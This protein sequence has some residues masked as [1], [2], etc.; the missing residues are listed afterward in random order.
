[1]LFVRVGGLS[2]K[3]YRKNKTSRSF[4][5]TNQPP[6][7]RGIYAFIFPYVE[8]FLWA[9]KISYDEDGNINKKQFRAEGYRKFDYEGW[10]WCHFIDFVG[11]LKDREV[12][13]G[14]VKVHTRELPAILAKVNHADCRQ[15]IRNN[16]TDD[17][18]AG[19]TGIKFPKN[20]YKRGQGGYMSIDHMEVFIEKV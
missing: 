13:R 3:S 18:A 11:D 19:M 20:A 1:M 5:K 9:W 16:H 6:K 15:L 4:N 2:S 7:N 12:I 10:L 8:S 17:F 14:W